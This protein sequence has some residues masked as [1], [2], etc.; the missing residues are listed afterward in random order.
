MKTE[1]DFVGHRNT[2]SGKLIPCF[3]V[4]VAMIMTEENKSE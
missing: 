2:E 3:S 1:K 4:S